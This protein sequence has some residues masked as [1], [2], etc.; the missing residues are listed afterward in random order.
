MASRAITTFKHPVGESMNQYWLRAS[1][2]LA[3]A[4]MIVGS[5]APTASSAAPAAPAAVGESAPARSTAASGPPAGEAIP[6]PPWPL[7]VVGPAFRKGEAG[8]LDAVLTLRARKAEAERN[9]AVRDSFVQS[10]GTLLA[11]V[12][13]T[14][15][16]RSLRKGG[17][18]ASSVA[19]AGEKPRDAVRAILGASAGHRLILLN[20]EHLSSAQRAFANQLLEGLYRQG[21]RYLAIEALR[22]PGDRIQKRGYPVVA[23]SGLYTRDPSLGDLIRRAIALGFKLLPYDLDVTAG[24]PLPDDKSPVDATNRREKAQA[25]SIFDQTFATDPGAKVVVYGGRHHIGESPAPLD[26][27]QFRPMGYEL[28]QLSGAEALSVDLI[29]M[30]E[31]A[32]PEDEYPARRAAIAQGL[33]KDKPIV[34]VGRDGRFW[35]SHPGFLD[36]DVFLPDTRFVHGR[37][38]WMRMGGLRKAVTLHPDVKAAARPLL[39]QAHFAD[40]DSSIAVPADQII[41]SPEATDATLMLRA[42]TYAIRAIDRDGKTWWTTTRKV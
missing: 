33:L 29:N 11:F 14:A 38:E 15:E 42:G 10:Y 28:E 16:G 2:W 12:G 19:V 23:G 40:E 22:E 4:S 18:E 35:T 41:I 8:Y 30:E 36:V 31:A 37:P 9:P 39:L 20:E 17:K 32:A 1:T 3:S 26:G 27:S 24:L 25:Q 5:C 13:E 6:T 21:Y 34:L 7:T